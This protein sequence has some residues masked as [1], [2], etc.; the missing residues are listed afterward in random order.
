LLG[1]VVVAWFSRRRE[2]RADAGGARLAGRE[3][4][5]GALQALQRRYEPLTPKNAY[6]TLQIAGRPGGF[7]SLMA[8]HP[9]LEARIA[10]LRAGEA[11]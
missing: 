6:S 10:A 1:T 2:F 9:P 7:L 11:R 8:S 3:K 5:I 4:M